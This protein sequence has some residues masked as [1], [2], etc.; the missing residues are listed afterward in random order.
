MVAIKL[1]SLIDD[2]DHKGWRSAVNA[3]LR[4]VLFMQSNIETKATNAGNEK[5]NKLTYLTGGQGLMPHLIQ[6]TYF[7]PPSHLF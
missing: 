1:D 3:T 5:F 2:F 4:C 6:E 7:D